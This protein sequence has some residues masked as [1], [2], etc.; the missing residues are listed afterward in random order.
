MLETPFLE[1]QDLE[2]EI[3]PLSKSTNDGCIIKA[4]IQL[5]VYTYTYIYTFMKFRQP[6]DIRVEREKKV[7]ISTRVRPDVR[8]KLEIASNKTPQKL[9]LA[10]LVE[11][12]LED[13]VRHI[14]QKGII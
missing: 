13:Y 6:A 12:V 8:K 1:L 11:Q 10:T 2:T 14:E 9:P 5:L 3:K 4:K 7:N